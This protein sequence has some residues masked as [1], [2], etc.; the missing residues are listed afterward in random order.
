MDISVSIGGGQNLTLTGAVLVYQGGREAFAVW[1]PAKSG[2]TEGAPYLGEAE[3]LTM[4][5]LRTL[6]TGLGVYVAPEVL[7]ASVL[8]RTSELLVW[9]APAYHRLLF[10]VE[11]SH[12][13]S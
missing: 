4:E 11:H 9:W 6:S 8:V 1:H 7:P 12:A 3:P 13:G 2:Q 10:F 5:F